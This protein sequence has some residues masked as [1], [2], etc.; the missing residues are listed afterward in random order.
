MGMTTITDEMQQIL[1]NYSP[2]VTENNE[3]II[4]LKDAVLFLSVDREKEGSLIIRIDPINERLD[5]TIKD[6]FGQ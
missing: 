3:V 4:G 5:W 2:Y 1:D 6:V